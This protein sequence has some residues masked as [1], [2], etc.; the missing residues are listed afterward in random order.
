MTSA[1]LINIMTLEDVAIYYQMLSCLKLTNRRGSHNPFEIWQFL[2]SSLMLKS[3]DELIVCIWR[4]KH[5]VLMCKQTK[6]RHPVLK[7]LTKICK[8][9]FALKSLIKYIF[10][11]NFGKR[12]LVIYI[13]SCE[14]KFSSRPFPLT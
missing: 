4:H 5:L 3:A 14:I 10:C 6:W 9:K 7:L 11:W 12:M 13:F 1:N 2:Q 8:F